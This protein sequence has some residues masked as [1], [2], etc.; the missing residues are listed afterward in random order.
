MELCHWG[1]RGQAEEIR[2]IAEA[3]SSA[4]VELEMLDG[5]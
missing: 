3:R 5:T 4:G 2:K 1:Q